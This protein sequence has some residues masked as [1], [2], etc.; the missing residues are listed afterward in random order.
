MDLMRLTERFG[1]VSCTCDPE[2][3]TSSMRTHRF[4]KQ[5][6]RLIDFQR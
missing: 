1:Q 5:Q 3:D 4:R 6:G 2:W